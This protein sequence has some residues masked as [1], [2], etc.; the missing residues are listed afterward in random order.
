MNLPAR[1][2]NIL[3]KPAAEWSVIAAEPADITSIFVGYVLIL[4]AIPAVCLFIGISLISAP[5]VGAFG[6]GAGLTGAIVGYVSGVVGVF[7][8]AFVIQQLAST[9]GSSGD[10][11]QAL[12]MVAYSYTPVWIAG[13]L[14]LVV[15]L[16]PLAILAALYAVYLFYVGLPKVM[17]T[18]ADKVVPYMIVSAV[19]V[20]VVHFVLQMLVTA[21]A[22]A[23][24][25]YGRM[26]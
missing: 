22:F 24:M 12:K 19:V 14:Y 7:I 4:A 16:A 15:L 8:A 5:I 10:Q 13:V 11:V 2:T 21:I 17:K 20:I 23:P 25:G 6:M 3:T 26:L 18:P 9:F 1:V